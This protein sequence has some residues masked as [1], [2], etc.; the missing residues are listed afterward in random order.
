MNE[1]LSKDRE[2]LLPA[3]G[4]FIAV[5]LLMAVSLEWLPWQG[6][7]LILKPDFV[8]LVLL[9]WC[10]HKPNRVGIG[11]AWMVGILADVADGTFF[12]EHALA[13]TVLAFGG[14]VLHRRI[15]MFDLHQQTIQ[16]FPLLLS[17]YATFAII[18]WQLR[19]DMAWEYF[20]GSVVSAS[21]WIPMTVL[22]QTLR[23]P[24]H[25]PDEL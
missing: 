3:S 18:H 1:G 22:L 5:S 17:S 7:G 13:Y 10:T 21:L 15:Q 19:G 23:R 14:A 9:Y 24:R 12:G 2:F 8:A 4:M 6:W 20:L 16:V 25:H 11:V